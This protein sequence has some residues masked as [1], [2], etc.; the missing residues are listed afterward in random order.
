MSDS[1]R[2][3][4][5]T[6]FLRVPAERREACMA[7]VLLALSLLEFAVAEHPEEGK[8]LDFVWTDDDK[9]EHKIIDTAGVEVV[10]LKVDK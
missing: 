6:D 9:G 3:T 8:I 2:I 7:E 4:C 10:S 5:L 1:Y